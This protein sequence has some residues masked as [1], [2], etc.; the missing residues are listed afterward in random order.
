M[1]S[2]ASTT[3]K[4]TREPGTPRVGARDLALVAAMAALIA[5]LG[6]PGALYPFGQAVPITLQSMGVML[7]GALLG[8]KRGGLALLL[9]LALGAAGLPVLAGGRPLL[10]ALP[11]PT[12]GF[13]VGYPLGAMCAGALVDRA[14]GRLTTARIALAVLVGGIGVVHLCGVPGMMWR[15]GLSLP[16]A[17]AADVVFLPGDLV[18]AV[19]ATVVAAS[20]HRALPTLLPSTWAGR[21]R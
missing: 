10:P 7:A 3:R 16:A 11:G 19:V 13:I 5:V 21:R 6:V 14:A 17:I 4:S 15:G 8:W 9:F 20:V 1:S 2:A 18:K 12:V